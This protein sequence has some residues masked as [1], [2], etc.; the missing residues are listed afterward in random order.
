[1][2]YSQLKSNL[3]NN[4][5]IGN[6][7]DIVSNLTHLY[8]NAIVDSLSENVTGASSDASSF[9]DTTNDVEVLFPSTH[10]PCDYFGDSVNFNCSKETYIQ[11]YRGAQQLPLITA[12]PVS[13]L[14][15]FSLFFIMAKFTFQE[16]LRYCI[17]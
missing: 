16:P 5:T 17:K 2:T 1:M 9:N 4:F 14:F 3:T 15:F 11:H 6:S 10:H 12:L 8:L 7:E 13:I